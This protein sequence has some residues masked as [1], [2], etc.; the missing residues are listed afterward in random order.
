MNNRTRFVRKGPHPAVSPVVERHATAHQT[1]AVLS[2]EP[3]ITLAYAPRR[4]DKTPLLAALMS[5]SWIVVGLALWAAWMMR[6]K[7][8]VCFNSARS[9]PHHVTLTFSEPLEL[10]KTHV[11]R[12]PHRLDELLKPDPECRDSARWRGPYMKNATQLKDGWG[13]HLIYQS[14]GLHNESSYDLSSPGPDGVPG[15]ADD[16]TN[17]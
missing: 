1:E 17:W 6:T 9:D 14:P 4:A 12:Y 2:D 5:L 13:Q 11:G 16:I 8:T 7:V 15:T 10:F 3:F